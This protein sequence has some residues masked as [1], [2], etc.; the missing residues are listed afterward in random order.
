MLQLMGCKS[1]RRLAIIVLDKDIIVWSLTV[2]SKVRLTV[3]CIVLAFC[4]AVYTAWHHTGCIHNESGP[5]EPEFLVL[6]HPSSCLLLFHAPPAGAPRWS[7]RRLEP[8]ASPSAPTGMAAYGYA[9]LYLMKM[10]T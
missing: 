10:I 3:Y 4:A 8:A 1:L 9:N 6:L 5:Q 7:C 2:C